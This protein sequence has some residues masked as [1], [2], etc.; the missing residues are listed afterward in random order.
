MQLFTYG[1]LVDHFYIIVVATKLKNPTDADLSKALEGSVK[2]ME[3]QGAKNIVLNQEDFATSNNVQGKKGFGTMI[4]F[5]PI[6]Q[7]NVKQYYEMI[8]FKEEQGLQQILIM[9]GVD[10]KYGKEIRERI[11]K[12]IELK[13]AK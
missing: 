6:T 11:I 9:H 8:C 10:D 7:K 3:A 1:S 5:D 2:A 4:A 12:S 13:E